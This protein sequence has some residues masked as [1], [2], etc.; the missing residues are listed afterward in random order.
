M[1]EYKCVKSGKERIVINPYK[2]SQVC[3]SC[4]HDDG[5]HGLWLFESGHAQPTTYTATVI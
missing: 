1:L 4:V 2:T 3:S 5:K